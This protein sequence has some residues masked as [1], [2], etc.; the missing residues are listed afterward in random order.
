M[1]WI[2][3][4]RWRLRERERI[5]SPS[6][7]ERDPAGAPRPLQNRYRRTG[8]E[9]TQEHHPGRRVLLR[10][11]EHPTAAKEGRRLDH[12]SGRRFHRFSW[13]THISFDTFFKCH[14]KNTPLVKIIWFSIFGIQLETP[15]VLK[16]VPW[17][18]D[19]KPPGVPDENT[20]TKKTPE[21]IEREIKL[22]GTIKY[23]FWVKFIP[24]RNQHS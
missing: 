20:M 1:V 10:H 18:A 2:N 8:A 22:Q 4:G 6:S 16:T 17:R 15:E 14:V 9:P 19:Y 5:R 7:S 23:Y 11:A 13:F 12:L 3:S 21:E 24:Y